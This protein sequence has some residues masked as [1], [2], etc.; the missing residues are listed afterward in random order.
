MNSIQLK[1]FCWCQLRPNFET[2]VC[3][4]VI[5]FKSGKEKKDLLTQVKNSLRKFQRR[6]KLSGGQDG[7]KMKVKLEDSYVLSVKEA[8]IADGWEPP[9]GTNSDRGPV[10]KGKKNPIGGDG[11]PLKCFQW[12]SEYH[13]RDKCDQRSNLRDSYKKKEKGKES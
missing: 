4:T 3:P 11:K 5:D 6:E 10:Q 8:L 7:C 2:E 9:R 12:Q 1:T 13:L